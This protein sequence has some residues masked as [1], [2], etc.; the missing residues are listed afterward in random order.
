MPPLV[1][2]TQST[3][4]KESAWKTMRIS[5]ARKLNGNDVTMIRCSLRSFAGV[6]LSAALLGPAQVEE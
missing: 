6:D 3:F 5:R 2:L 1:V 4:R